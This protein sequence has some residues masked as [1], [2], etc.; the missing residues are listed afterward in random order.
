MGDCVSMKDHLSLA[1]KRPFDV[2]AEQ[3][4]LSAHN[5]TIFRCESFI[6]TKFPLDRATVD[7]YRRILI[8]SHFVYIMLQPREED[9]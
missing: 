9:F 5:S 8:E 4:P 2:P 1:G 7:E 3:C 6:N